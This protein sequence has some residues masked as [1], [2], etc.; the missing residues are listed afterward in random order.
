MS[1]RRR[2][3][4]VHYSTERSPSLRRVHHIEQVKWVKHGESDGSARV[5]D[6]E[7]VV[8]KIENEGK[9]YY[10]RGDDGVEAAV[11]VAHRKS[12]RA[13]LHTDPDG[14]ERDNLLALPTF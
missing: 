10:V 7:Q 14:D 8:R 6:V 9:R 2:I 13:Y 4:A 1:R 11:Q 5:R 12:G 3:I